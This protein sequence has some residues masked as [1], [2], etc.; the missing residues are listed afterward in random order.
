M[1][2]RRALLLPLLLLASSLM[3][4]ADAP[5]LTG[6]VTV[7]E[8]ENGALTAPHAV[9][10]VVLSDAEWKK[11]LDAEAYKVLRAA[12]T[13]RPF[14]G[15][16]L[17]NKGTGYYVCA[18]CGLPLFQAADKFDSGTGWPSFSKEVYPGNVRRITDTSYGMERTE[19]RCARCDGHLGHVFDD[20]PAP[21][22]TR[23]CLN[24]AA[25][26]FVAVADK[27]PAK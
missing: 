6:P 13:E 11:K 23:H 18:G 5:I 26:T 9:P 20:G 21:T 1:I 7:V 25:L 4:A 19:I 16:L 24:S 12:G 22:H 10:R 15:G 3:S 27:A 8:L 14:C 17:H 2:M